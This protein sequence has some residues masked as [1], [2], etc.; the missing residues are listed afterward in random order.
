MPV[1]EK[2]IV[3]R[4][5]SAEGQWLI[6]WSHLPKEEVTWEDAEECMKKFPNYNFENSTA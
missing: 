1:L 5:N 3:K 6:Q 2:M 4:N